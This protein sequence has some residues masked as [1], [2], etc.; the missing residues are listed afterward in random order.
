MRSATALAWGLVEPS[1]L[2]ACLASAV[3]RA[4]EEARQLGHGY[5]GIEHL[6]LG[7][8]AQGHGVGA[9]TL[10][11][12]SIDLDQVRADVVETPGPTT[13]PRRSGHRPFGR[14]EAVPSSLWITRVPGRGQPI[15]GVDSDRRDAQV[16]R[17][18]P[19][20]GQRR[21]PP[22]RCTGNCSVRWA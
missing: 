1:A 6:L 7:I 11:R 14:R 18:V 16:R 9:D 19:S 12:L 20:G 10:A 15:A 8:L 21:F 3:V 2:E 17:P 13:G 4:Q 22:R 5:I